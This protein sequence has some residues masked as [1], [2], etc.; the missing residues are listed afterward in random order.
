MSEEKKGLVKDRILNVLYFGIGFPLMYWV[1]QTMIISWN[2]E[3]LL[4]NY[5]I[6]L[7]G[8]SVFAILYI[9]PSRNLFLR[10]KKVHFFFIGFFLSWFLSDFTDFLI[11]LGGIFS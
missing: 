1:V 5:E 3:A 8:L 9:V 4:Q 10:L 11:V 7:I 2:N 6:G